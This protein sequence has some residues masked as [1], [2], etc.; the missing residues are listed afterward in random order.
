MKRM[1][2]RTKVLI[3]TVSMALLLIAVYAFGIL[4]PESAYASSFMNA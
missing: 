3:L 1:N 2:S 4:I